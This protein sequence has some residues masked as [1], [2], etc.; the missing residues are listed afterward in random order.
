[1]PY[2]IIFLGK[3]GCGKG[4]QAEILSKRLS[5]P[6]ISTGSMYRREMQAGTEVG[7]QVY[8]LCVKQGKLMPDEITNQLMAK[9]IREADCAGGFIIDGY[10]RTLNQAEFIVSDINLAIDIDIPDDLAVQ[11]LDGRWIHKASGRTYHSEFNPPKIAYTD[12]ITGEGL[13]QREDDRPEIIKRRLEVFYELCAPLP[14][15]FRNKGTKVL[16]VSGVGAIGE[17]ASRIESQL[18]IGRLYGQQT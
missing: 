11:R 17:I 10:P 13:I 12:D 14:D 2:K 6:T 5:I 8:E 4:T 9:R 3:L 15:F 18:N 1:M 16:Q 7:N